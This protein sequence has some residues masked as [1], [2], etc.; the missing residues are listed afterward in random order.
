VEGSVDRAQHVPD[1]ARPDGRYITNG[2]SLLS[3]TQ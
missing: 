2:V 3:T 1:T